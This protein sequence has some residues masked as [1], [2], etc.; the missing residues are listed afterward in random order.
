MKEPTKKV[1]LNSNENL[2]NNE[3]Y[4]HDYMPCYCIPPSHYVKCHA[5][6]IEIVHEYSCCKKPKEIFR[7]FFSLKAAVDL[8]MLREQFRLR[9][10]LNGYF[11]ATTHIFF[12]TF[13]HFLCIPLACLLLFQHTYTHTL[14]RLQKL[15]GES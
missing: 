8:Y 2:I 11:T 4:S 6:N 1:F 5:K 7:F 12:H 15:L 9:Q 13:S 10:M 14:T 3:M